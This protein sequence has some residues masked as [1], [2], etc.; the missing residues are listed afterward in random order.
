M[1]DS[2][3]REKHTPVL[4]CW[5]LSSVQKTHTHART[6]PS[7]TDEHRKRSVSSVSL[8]HLTPNFLSIGGNDFL[9]TRNNETK[10][11][12]PEVADLGPVVRN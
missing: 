12:K 7:Q 8:I 4:G 3:R 5:V 2:Q 6:S 9:R 11:S 10:Q 1:D